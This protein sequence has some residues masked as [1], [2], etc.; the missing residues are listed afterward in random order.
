M[1]TDKRE[2]EGER[3]IWMGREGREERARREGRET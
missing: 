1:V 2:E 3:E